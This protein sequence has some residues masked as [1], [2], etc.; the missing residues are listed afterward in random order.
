MAPRPTPAVSVRDADVDGPR[1]GR[2]TLIALCCF[3]AGLG[4]PLLA[5]LDFV[6]RPPGSKPLEPEESEPPALDPSPSDTEPADLQP[7]PTPKPGAPRPREDA[8]RAAAS[9]APLLTEREGLRIEGKEIT[10]C[11]DQDRAVRG[12]CDSPALDP[13]LAEPLRAL[14]ECESAQGVSGLLS[15]GLELDFGRNQVM[16]VRSGH[17]TSL[18]EHVTAGLLECAESRLLGKSL[19]GVEHR[20]GSYWLHYRIRFVPPG[21]PLEA[22]A[23]AQRMVSMSG[24]ATIGAKVGKVRGEPASQAPIV[25]RL[26][27]GARVD[28]TGRM[29][30]WYRVKYGREARTG[31]VYRKALGL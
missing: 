9:V 20:H 31:W 12:P 8:V 1:W 30:D 29:G 5:G 7:S 17:S 26:Q 6:Q 3:A 28:V 21:S 16:S 15:L 19:A 18:S 23:D 11:K 25:D 22:G 2:L 24:Q 13:V 4:W 10:S 14:T 27:Y